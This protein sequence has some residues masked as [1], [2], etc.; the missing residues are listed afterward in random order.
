MMEF[1]ER[2]DL[3]EPPDRKVSKVLPG[4]QELMDLTEKMHMV[5]Q[6]TQGLRGY[7][8]RPGSMVRQGLD[9]RA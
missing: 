9:S 5:F 3:T 2:L 4:G 6:E 1:P 7:L 8:V